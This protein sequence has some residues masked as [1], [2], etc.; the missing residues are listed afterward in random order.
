MQNSKLMTLSWYEMNQI[1]L[2]IKF[3][4]LVDSKGK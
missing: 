4:A 2:G 3:Y 1:G